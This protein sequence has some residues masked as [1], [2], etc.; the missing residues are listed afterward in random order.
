MRTLEQ[1]D[2]EYAQM[3]GIKG[4]RELLHRDKKRIR[5]YTDSKEH[6]IYLM[7]LLTKFNNGGKI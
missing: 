4:L 5:E 1:S 2:L 6:T 7:Q 3:M